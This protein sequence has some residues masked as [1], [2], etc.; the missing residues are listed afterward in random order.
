MA[1]KEG[2][3]SHCTL[4]LWLPEA[5][6]EDHLHL[7]DDDHGVALMDLP[8]TED[9]QGSLKIVLDASS[10][11]RAFLVCRLYDWDIFRWF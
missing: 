9:G 2:V 10:G 8:L 6:S 3:L 1:L 4:Q 7:N 5:A 11:R